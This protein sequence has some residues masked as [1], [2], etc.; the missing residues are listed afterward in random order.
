MPCLSKSNIEAIEAV[1]RG[2]LRKQVQTAPK[3]Y[4]CEESGVD[5]ISNQ[6]EKKMT[7]IYGKAM[8]MKVGS[9]LKVASRREK[10]RLKRGKVVERR[11]DG[12]ARD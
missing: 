1:Q 12:R 3:E 4:V 6:L 5:Q 9:L 7:E 2:A 8:K 10:Q 11:R